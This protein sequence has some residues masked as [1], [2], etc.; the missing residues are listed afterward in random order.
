MT[1][2]WI[3]LCC[4]VFAGTAV[5]LEAVTIVAEYALKRIAGGK[6]WKKL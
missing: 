5:L 4:V 6:L 3:G 2:F 1:M